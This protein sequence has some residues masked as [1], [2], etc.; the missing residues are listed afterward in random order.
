MYK[1]FSL[2]NTH[3]VS[4]KRTAFPENYIDTV[5]DKVSVGIYWKSMEAVMKHGSRLSCDVILA[6]ILNVLGG[7]Q[8]TPTIIDPVAND[9][10]E[11]A[12][13]MDGEQVVEAEEMDEDNHRPL[14]V[15]ELDDSPIVQ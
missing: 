7:K 10:I 8:A 11:A 9:E 2:L 1:V 6:S 14:H 4:T 5:K 13:L 3:T 15:V 12:D